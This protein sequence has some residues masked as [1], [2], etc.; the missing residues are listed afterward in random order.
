MKVFKS[1]HEL[2]M[3][4]EHWSVYGGVTSILWVFGCYLY[5]RDNYIIYILYFLIVPHFSYFIIIL[6]GGETL[7]GNKLPVLKVV[8]YTCLTDPRFIA[9]IHF[10]PIYMFVRFSVHLYICYFAKVS[11]KRIK[12]I[13]N[14]VDTKHGHVAHLF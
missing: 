13:K 12:L 14:V 10:G 2:F 4:F 1:R 5:L 11:N 9:F 8:L 6:L 3:S 7:G